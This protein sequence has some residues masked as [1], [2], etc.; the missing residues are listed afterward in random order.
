MEAEGKWGK[1][2]KERKWKRKGVVSIYVECICSWNVEPLERFSPS[3][4]ATWSALDKVDS[5]L[6]IESLRSFNGL[7]KIISVF[8]Y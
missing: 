6:F 3:Q 2:K 8:R 7:V 5:F 1:T 4:A